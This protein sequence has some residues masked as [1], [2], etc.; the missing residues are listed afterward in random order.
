MYAGV[1]DNNSSKTV[2]GSIGLKPCENAWVKFLGFAGS[3]GGPGDPGGNSDMLA[4]GQILAGTTLNQEKNLNLATELTYM[5]W[6][7]TSVAD[8]GDDAVAMSAGLW[9]WGDLCERLGWAVRGDYVNDRDGAFTSGLLGF[10]MNGG[11]ELYSA[12]FT[13]NFSPTPQIKI[14]PEVRF[15]RTTLEDGFDGAEGR[16]IAGMGASYIF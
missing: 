13:L 2:M 15:E 10:P 8:P 16:V 9:V 3:E 4:G 14:Q 11:Q 7:K 6:D 12:T 5:H 1:K